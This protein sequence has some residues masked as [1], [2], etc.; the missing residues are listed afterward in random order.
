M[1]LAELTRKIYGTHYVETTRVQIYANSRLRRV[2]FCD[3]L[4]GDEE[5]PADFKVFVLNSTK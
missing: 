5:L 4:F 3:K 1:N 2:Y